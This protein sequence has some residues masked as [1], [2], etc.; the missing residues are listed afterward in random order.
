MARWF[1]VKPNELTL[2]NGADGGL[3]HIVSTF[4]E[5]RNTILLVEP[6]FVMY[7]FYAQR[8]G[9]RVRSLRYDY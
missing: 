1:G 3:Q 7:S 6:T 2:T 4:V 9:A 5:P 8:A